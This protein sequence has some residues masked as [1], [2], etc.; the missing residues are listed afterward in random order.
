[1]NDEQ[2]IPLDVTDPTLPDNYLQVK[3]ALDDS[4]EKMLSRSRGRKADAYKTPE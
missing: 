2:P 4:V 3:K 1:M